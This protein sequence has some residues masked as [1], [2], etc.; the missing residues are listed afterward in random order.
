MTRFLITAAA[1]AFATLPAMAD[2]CTPPEKP[3]FDQDP[4]TMEVSDLNAATQS[5]MSYEKASK[6]YRSCLDGSIAARDAQWVTSLESFNAS[7]NEQDEVYA[8]YDSMSA[9]FNEAAPERAARAALAA[10]K[11]AEE[12]F[13]KSLA[14]A[15]VTGLE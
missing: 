15:G 9:A 5:L 13:A 2:D 8:A 12:K 1:L 11:E 3:V 7:A 6:D 14:E 4:A 10:K